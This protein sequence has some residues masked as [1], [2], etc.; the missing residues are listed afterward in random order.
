M[1]RIPKQGEFYRHFK[2]NLYQ[3][4]AIA[5][6]SETMEEMVVYQALYGTYGVYVRPL[7]MFISEV[8]HEKYPEVTQVYRFEHVTLENNSTSVEEVTEG[9]VIS[10]RKTTENQEESSFPQAE[11]V[12][13]KINPDILAFLEANGYGEKLEVLFAVRKRVDEEVLHTMAIAMDFS[14]SEGDFQEQFDSF[15]Y[16]LETHAKF[17]TTRLR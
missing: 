10:T 5:K 15:V 1:N 7:S 14:L 12:E 11:T 16:F 8:D 3:V 9:E 2:G 17:E 4:Q 13:G 6:H